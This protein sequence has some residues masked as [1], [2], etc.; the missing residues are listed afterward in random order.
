MKTIG[1]DKRISN[2]GKMATVEHGIS[3]NQEKPFSVRIPGGHR[4]KITASIVFAQTVMKCFF[5]IVVKFCMYKDR[6]KCVLNLGY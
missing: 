2:K 4:V 6:R 1:C 5:R 3:I